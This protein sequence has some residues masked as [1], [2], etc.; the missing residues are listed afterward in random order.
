MQNLTGLSVEICGAL[1]SFASF[2][3]QGWTGAEIGLMRVSD[4]VNQ[5]QVF[6]IPLAP[7]ADP[8]V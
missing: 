2:G 4:V 6:E 8:Q 7:R 1:Y 3:R 5:M